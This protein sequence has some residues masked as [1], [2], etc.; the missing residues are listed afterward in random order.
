MPISPLYRLSV[1]AVRGAACSLN[2][3]CHAVSLPVVSAP[4]WLAAGVMG[5]LLATTSPAALAV[6]I[7]GVTFAALELGFDRLKGHHL[8]AHFPELKEESLRNDI[9]FA[10]RWN[11][12]VRACHQRVDEHNKLKSC[13]FRL[14][15]FFE[16]TLDNLDDIAPE[17]ECPFLGREIWIDPTG[18]FNVCCAP[19]QQRKTLGDFGN[20]NGQLLSA[21]ASSS[22][23]QELAK[24]YRTHS[25]CQQCNM[26]RPT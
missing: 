21:L 15:N 8:W 14:D 4:R 12:I 16:L 26:R 19:D 1:S 25:L 24:N 22:Q 23:Y 10:D 2:A 11:Q 6:E 13:K 18:R 17:G 9:T 20:V 7:K 3:A 5:A